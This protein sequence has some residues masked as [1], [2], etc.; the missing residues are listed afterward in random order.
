MSDER[1]KYIPALLTILRTKTDGDHPMKYDALMETLKAEYGLTPTRKTVAS[2][3]GTLIELG[4]PLENRHG[5]YYEHEFCPAELNLL[6]DSVL[7]ASQITEEQ[8]QCL[9]GKLRSLGGDHYVPAVE[10]AQAKLVNPAFMQNLELL[11]AAIA[12]QKQVSFHYADFGMDKK[13]H[14]RRNDRKRPKVYR[15]NPYR[16]A[17]ANGR[18]Y[19]ICNADK[20]DSL[21]HFRVERILDVRILKTKA[22]PLSRMKDLDGPMDIQAYMAQHP[23]MYTG[24]PGKYLLRVKKKWINE[25]LDTFGM[26]ITLTNE[27]EETFDALVRSDAV[28]VDFWLKKFAGDAE[29]VEGKKK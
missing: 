10:S 13:L 16:I 1:S 19:L 8:R 21:C 26:E 15:I 25:V 4:F 2:N 6:I 28:S 24:K 20:Y 17:T 23:L 5:W 14:C 3:I 27:T 22:K 9:V 18:Y 12:G 7:S 29:L 11:H